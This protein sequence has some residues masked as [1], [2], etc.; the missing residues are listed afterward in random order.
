M[1]PFRILSLAVLATLLLAGCEKEDTAAP[2]AATLLET[3]WML[4]RIDNFPVEASS[5]SETRRSYLEFVDLGQCTVGLGPCNNFSGRF[6]LGSSNN[7]QLSISPQIPTRATCPVQ[8]L[9]NQ[10]LANLALTQRY[11]L[12]GDELRLYDA[13]TAAPRLVFRRAAAQ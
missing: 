2:A 10:Y 9:E 12:E 1:M 5:Y 8:P 13:T 11:A 7:Q 4:A 6:S 3:R